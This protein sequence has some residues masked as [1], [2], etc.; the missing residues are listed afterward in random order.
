MGGN[1]DGL[2]TERKKIITL[3]MTHHAQYDRFDIDIQPV[4]DLGFDGQCAF[5]VS[6]P[7]L[8]FRHIATEKRIGVS[9]TRTGS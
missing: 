1:P 3:C 2:R 8:N 9:V 5:Y 6:D 4:T 7:I